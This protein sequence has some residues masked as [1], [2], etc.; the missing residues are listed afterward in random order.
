M[1]KPIPLAAPQIGAAEIAAVTRVLQSGRLSLGEERAAFERE[2]AHCLGVNY[3][4]AVSSGTAALHLAVHACGMGPGDEAITTPFSF[5]ASTNCLL[6][7]NV[8]PVFV[9]IDEDSLNIDHTRIEA[10]IT[11]ATRTIIGVDIFGYPAS[12]QPIMDVARQYGLELIEDA[13]EAL[14]AEY[15]G[16]RLGNYGHPTIFSFYPNKQITTAEGG[17]ITTNDEQ[18]YHLFQS[19]S[20]QGRGP[21]LQQLAPERLGFNYRINEMSAALGRV[22]LKRLDS[23]LVNRSRVA[24]WY[25]QRLQDIDVV[26]LPKEDD[27]M[28]KRSWFAFVLRLAP[29]IDRDSVIARLALDGIAS[30]AYL[31]SIHLLPHLRKHGYRMGDFPVS[32]AVSASTLALPFYAGMEEEAVDRVCVGLV[33]I[34]TRARPR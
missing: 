2:L 3:A 12:W 4:I 31:P 26:A 32:E 33:N 14:G 23:I 1:T 28:H 34:L 29:H 11:S 30:K 8:R 20:N 18:R 6:Y 19:L 9:D 13:A 27:E 24:Q 21:D 16:R 7:E 5:V 22:Q 10:A 25:R 15:R 17:A